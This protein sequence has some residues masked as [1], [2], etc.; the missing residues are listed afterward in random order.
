MYKLPYET[1][2]STVEP[3]EDFLWVSPEGD[4]AFFDPWGLIGKKDESN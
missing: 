2:S 1:A 3:G 4:N